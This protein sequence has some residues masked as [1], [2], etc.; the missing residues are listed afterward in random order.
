MQGYHYICKSLLFE[1][2]V[3]NLPKMVTVQL[4]HGCKIYV[5]EIHTHI[6]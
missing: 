5:G 4:F 6:Q 1:V 2:P 3:Y